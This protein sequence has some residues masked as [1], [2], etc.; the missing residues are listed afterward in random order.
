MSEWSVVY[1][2]QAERY[3][4]SIFEYIAFSLFEPEIAKNQSQRIMDAVAKLNEMPLRYHL[5]GKEPWY[6]KR[7][8]GIANRQLFGILSACESNNDGR[9]CPHYVRW[10]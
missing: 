8:A 7:L 10:T 5:C 4:R 6:S 3:L 1:T 9:G 2:E